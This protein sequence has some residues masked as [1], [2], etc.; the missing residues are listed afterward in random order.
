MCVAGKFAMSFI[1]AHVGKA[2]GEVF[3]VSWPLAAVVAVLLALI[4]VAMFRIDWVKLAE[5]YAQKKKR[6]MVSSQLGIN[7]SDEV[8]NQ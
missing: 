7:N 8:A 4:V 2:A 3:V 5:R 6:K 1:I